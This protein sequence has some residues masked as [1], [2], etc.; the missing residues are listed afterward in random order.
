MP[1]EER[2]AGEH[3]AKR[4]R[5]DLICGSAVSAVWCSRDVFLTD[6]RY[7]KKYADKNEAQL[8][9]IPFRRQEVILSSILY[10]CVCIN[11]GV[12]SE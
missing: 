4:H 9:V 3:V 7:R 8:F 11:T 2:I 12:F 1:Q 6:C 5:N 10:C